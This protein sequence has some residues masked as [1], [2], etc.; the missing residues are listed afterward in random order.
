[1]IITLCGSARF[2]EGWHFWNERLT[3]DGHTV[4]SLAVFPSQKGTKNWYDEETKAKLD[5]AH[6]RK[7][8]ASDAIFVVSGPLHAHARYI[9]ESTAREVAHAQAEGKPVFYSDK[10]CGYAG[11]TDRLHSSPPC[12]LCYE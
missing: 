10:T 4:F 12:G 9:G 7:I 3:M 2:E 6:I 1:M 8:N 11:C 5:S